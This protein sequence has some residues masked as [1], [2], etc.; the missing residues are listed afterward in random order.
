[1]EVQNEEDDDDEEVDEEFDY[2]E[3]EMSDN[4]DI[5]DDEDAANDMEEDVANDTEDIFISMTRDDVRSLL[6][7]D[8]LAKRKTGGT[9]IIKKTKIRLL[10]KYFEEDLK[11][12]GRSVGIDIDLRRNLLPWGTHFDNMKLGEQGLNSITDILMAA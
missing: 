5:S 8:L 9:F 3:E 12:A 7:K 10:L 4:D 11:K 6:L 2:D 1:M